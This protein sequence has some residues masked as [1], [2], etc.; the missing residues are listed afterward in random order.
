MQ[1]LNIKTGGSTGR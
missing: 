1:Y